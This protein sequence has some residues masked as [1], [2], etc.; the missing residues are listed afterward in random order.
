M[1][2]QPMTV[3]EL[4]DALDRW[5]VNKQ[6]RCAPVMVSDWDDRVH[7]ILSVHR[8]DYGE[9]LGRRALV[10]WTMPAAD[11]EVR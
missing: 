9:D 10:L 8:D 4:R 3:G 1:A 6:G 7:V 11:V 5:I 2:T